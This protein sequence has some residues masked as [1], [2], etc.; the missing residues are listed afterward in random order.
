MS[1][2]FIPSPTGIRCLAYLQTSARIQRPKNDQIGGGDK[3][4][5]VVRRFKD[6]ADE[7]SVS[8]NHAGR[9]CTR[10]GY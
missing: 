10:M 3:T 6:G 9:G 2:A 7:R 8:T 5:W 4:R 1:R